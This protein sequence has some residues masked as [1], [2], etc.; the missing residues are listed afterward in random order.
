[1]CRARS[2]SPEN[3]KQAAMEGGVK[4]LLICSHLLSP[5]S[6]KESLAARLR[7]CRSS[8]LLSAGRLED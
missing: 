4:H 5:L 1:M 8:V 6:R 7:A 3:P 2:L